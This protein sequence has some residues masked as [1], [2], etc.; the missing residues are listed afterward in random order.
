[1][2][3]NIKNRNSF[4]VLLKTFTLCTRQ[5]VTFYATKKYFLTTMQLDY[6][7]LSKR[8]IRKTKIDGENEAKLS[9]IILLYKKQ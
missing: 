4:F 1:M 7:L 2:V 9:Y 8:M 6:A 5:V 3:H